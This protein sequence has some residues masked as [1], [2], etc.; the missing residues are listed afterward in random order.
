MSDTVASTSWRVLT[1]VLLVIGIAVV[2]VPRLIGDEGSSYRLATVQGTDPAIAAA[3]E[4]AGEAGDFDVVVD[5]VP[6]AAAAQ[7]AVRDGDADAGL[8]VTGEGSTLF[9]AADFASPFPALVSQAVVAQATAEALLEAGL[10]P[11]QILGLSQVPPPEQVTVGRVADEGRA[12]VGFAVGIVLYIALISAGT[13]IAT[14]VATEKST[15]ISEVLLAVLRPSQLLVGTVLGVGLLALLQ[16]AALAVPV[17]IGLATGNTLSIPAA[18]AGDI[19]LGVLWFVLGILL[20]AFIFAALAT[21]VEKPTEIGSATLPVNAILIASY[22]IAVT[23]TVAD[24]NAWASVLASLFPLSAPMVM[25]VRWASGL[26]PPWQLV[27]SMLLVAAT[28]VVLAAGAS[29][30]YA[31]G[32]AR[33]GRRLKLREVLRD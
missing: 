19:G 13:T 1:A 3:V 20:Y 10:S 9:V 21:L 12:A 14:A 24:P 33:T 16:V 22:L 32:L 29:R 28:A 11:Q 30:V 8:V 27:L 25:P 17:L 31:R 26:V 6:D 7:A 5:T 15:R 4:A 2:V 18:A 23:I